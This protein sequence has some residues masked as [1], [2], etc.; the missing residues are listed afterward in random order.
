MGHEVLGCKEDWTHIDRPHEVELLGSEV[1]HVAAA[2][3]KPSITGNDVYASPGLNHYVGE[4]LVCILAR[5]IKAEGERPIELIGNRLGCSDIDIGHH[6]LGALGRETTC[7]RCS[8]AATGAGHDYSLVI[9]SHCA[10]SAS[11][12]TWSRTG[13]R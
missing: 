12:R 7:D 5:D 11:L 8:E 9:K 3:R 13:S 1:H 4:F 10:S 6:D 2:M